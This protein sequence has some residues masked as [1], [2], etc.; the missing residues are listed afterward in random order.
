MVG[1]FQGTTNEQI[2]VSEGKK[3]ETQAPRPMEVMTIASCPE[4]FLFPSWYRTHL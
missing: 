2:G 4:A 1:G 3:S